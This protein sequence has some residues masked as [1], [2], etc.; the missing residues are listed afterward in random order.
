MGACQSFPMQYAIKS[1][2]VI[3]VVAVADE[4]GAR[5]ER[6]LWSRLFEPS[7]SN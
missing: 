1:D 5:D 3:R 2:I 6:L 4:M 7:R